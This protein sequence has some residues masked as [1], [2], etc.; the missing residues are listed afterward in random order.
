M[1]SPD[2][3]EYVVTEVRRDKEY[4]NSSKGKWRCEFKDPLASVE[5]FAV[6]LH[7][8]IVVLSNGDLALNRWRQR[9]LNWGEKFIGEMTGTGYAGL[10]R[11]DR[12]VDE[13]Q[14]GKGWIAAT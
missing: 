14:L 10:D 11:S 6:D 12:Y 5:S 8:D 7:D 13:R 1:T 2:R 3:D 4:A 9:C